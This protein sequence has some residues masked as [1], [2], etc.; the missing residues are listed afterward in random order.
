MSMPVIEHFRSMCPM[1]DQNPEEILEKV[2]IEEGSVNGNA[3]FV[4]IPKA[5]GDCTAR[6]AVIYFH[7]GSFIM[8]SPVDWKKNVLSKQYSPIL[9]FFVQLPGN[10]QKLKPPLG[11]T[12]LMIH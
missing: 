10:D 4:Y 6:S 2:D 8:S 5:L 12:M 9:L 11:F 3:G 1:L 7:G